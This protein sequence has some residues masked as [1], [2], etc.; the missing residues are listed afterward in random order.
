MAAKKPVKRKR[1]DDNRRGD[2]K[3]VW[4]RMRE[5]Q[6]ACGCNTHTLKTL[7]KAVQPFCDVKISGT[8]DGDLCAKGNAV[9]LELHGCVNCNDFVFAPEDKQ[10]R[11]PKC[12]HPR[13]NADKKPNEVYLFFCFF[14][15]LNSIVCKLVG[16]LLILFAWCV[17]RRCFGTSR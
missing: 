11:C 1:A 5:A 6:R 16:R 9:V 2:D 14:F 17:D 7:L 8:S 4:E 13:F 10:L 3:N 12:E 15:M